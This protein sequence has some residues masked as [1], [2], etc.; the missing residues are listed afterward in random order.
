[1]KIAV[2]GTGFI[3]N[4]QASFLKNVDG[5]EIECVM[6]VKQELVDRYGDEHGVTKRYTDFDDVLK[7]ENVDMVYLGVPNFLHYPY[8][9]KALEGG[10]HV[11]VEKPFVD[12]VEEAQEL[13][14][15]A[16]EKD[17]LIFDAITT[18]YMPGLKVLKEK[19]SDAG[20]LSMVTTTYAQYSHRFDGVRD[21]NY[22][23]AFDLKYQGG[24][25]KDLGIYPVTFNVELFGA[26]KDLKYYPNRLENGCDRS[27]LIVMEYEDFVSTSLVAKD[28]FMANRCE[29]TGYD[30]T[31]TVDDD[32]F[33]FPNLK[34]S[35]SAKQENV[36]LINTSEKP[37]HPYEWLEFK[38]IFEKH[39]TQRA[40]AY[41]ENTMKIMEVMRKLAESADIRYGE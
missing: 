22:D 13:L 24:A 17:L 40:Y 23:R 26:P 6:D 35:K 12:T 8:A 15:L 30:G 39:D 38:D 29:I 19:L 16:K 36:E 9:K 27:G 7:D 5:V 18:R 32:C 3:S 37:A 25:L 20:K 10:K 41:I 11:I 2:I 14:N 31:F 28:S 21:G 33:R 1:M 34:F 4:M